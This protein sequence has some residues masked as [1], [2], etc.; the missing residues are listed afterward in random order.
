MQAQQES[1]FAPIAL[2]SYYVRCPLQL[3]SFNLTIPSLA[4]VVIFLSFMFTVFLLSYPP[5]LITAA[6]FPV[7]FLIALFCTLPWADLNLLSL[8]PFLVE[9]LPG[10][11]A[12]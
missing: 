9:G 6:S 8:P 10:N 4:E 2:S 7:T 11:S 3:S 1:T 12:V 5:S